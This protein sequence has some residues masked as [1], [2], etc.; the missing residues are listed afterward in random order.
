MDIE[1]LVN[2]LFITFIT[3]LIIASIFFIILLSIAT[4]E[5]NQQQRLN[6]DNLRDVGQNV[7]LKSHSFFL[8]NLKDCYVHT[9]S[10]F[11]PYDRWKAISGVTE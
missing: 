1:D 5:N 9:T 3:V 6:C 2:G 4:I 8:L 11:V 7:T 10:G